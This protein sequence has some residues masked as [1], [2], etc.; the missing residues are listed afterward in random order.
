VLVLI[1]KLSYYVHGTKNNNIMDLFEHIMFKDMKKKERIFAC[2][3]CR[4]GGNCP[5]HYTRT[6]LL[7]VDDTRLICLSRYQW[8]TVQCRPPVALLHSFQTGLFNLVVMWVNASYVLLS[9]YRV[10][11]EPQ[12]TFK[13]RWITECHNVGSTI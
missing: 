5:A 8:R 9:E 11:E 2:V 12:V 10:L 6:L 3:F 13:K 1:I 4:A 7:L